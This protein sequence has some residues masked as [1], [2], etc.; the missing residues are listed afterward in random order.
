[1]SMYAMEKMTEAQ[2]TAYIEAHNV[3]QQH[4]SMQ[5][6]KTKLESTHH[7]LPTLKVP[8]VAPPNVDNYQNKQSQDHGFS[9]VPDDGLGY[10][11]GIR[12][13]RSIGTWAP[14]Y[15]T[16]H[17]TFQNDHN[18]F[19]TEAERK[20][21]P[22]TLHSIHTQ[23][24][25]TPPPPPPPIQQPALPQKQK[26]QKIDNN[27]K[28]FTC[29]ECGKGLARKDKLVIHMRIHTGEKP[30]V[31]EV[32]KKAFARRDKLVIHMNKLKHVTPSN[33]AP[34]SKRNQPSVETKS[35]QI[36]MLPE[37]K[38]IKDDELTQSPVPQTVQA[39]L[40][41]WYFPQQIIN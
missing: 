6:H 3:M 35:T 22:P 8:Q 33:L 14:D 5:Q 31:C 34:L 21:P 1:M 37:K 26:P 4:L 13:L 25:T 12:V 18:S 38:E 24:Q 19:N 10:D 17:A 15:P 36:C 16:L 28:T 27:N 39:P 2:K 30:Y 29:T 9:M 7:Y 41:H 20:P 11:D 32:C 40:H 23:T